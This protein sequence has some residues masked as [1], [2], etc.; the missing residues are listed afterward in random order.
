DT[1]I[2]GTLNVLMAAR[3]LGTPKI[4]H[5]STSEVYGTA[6][7]VPIDENHPLQGQSPYSAT[8]I[9]ADKLAESF[10]LSFQTPVVTLRPFNTFGPRQSARAIIPA[11]AVQVLMGQPV[12]LGS[13]T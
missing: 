1:N 8:K 5:T 12:K 10:F 6:R 3:A 13:L 4:I 7:Y 2:G 11:I 9:A